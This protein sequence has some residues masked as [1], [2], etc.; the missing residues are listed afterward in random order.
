LLSKTFSKSQWE[1]C[2][3]QAEPDCYFDEELG[4]EVCIAPSTSKCIDTRDIG[5][6]ITPI[7]GDPYKCEDELCANAYLTNSYKAGLTPGQSSGKEIASS[8]SEESL[9]FFIGTPCRAKIKAGSF[10]RDVIITCLW[11]V[12]PLL[13]DY[14]L[15]AM[16][17]VP[18]QEG[19]PSTFEMYWALVEKAMEL[20]AAFYEL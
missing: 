2:N 4:R 5:V 11:D 17:K 6:K 16:Y 13:L 14:K 19:F 8:N 9:M 10:S 15:Q 12:S 18:G 3:D 7:Y 20:S 1:G